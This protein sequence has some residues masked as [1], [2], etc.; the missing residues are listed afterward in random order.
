MRDQ[1]AIRSLDTKDSPI[2]YQGRGLADI[3]VKSYFDPENQAVRQT[4]LRISKALPIYAMEDGSAIFVANGQVSSLGTIY[5]I[6]QG[7]I[8][9]IQASGLLA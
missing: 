5:W 8:A 7:N 1:R 4:L 3:T 9:P 2:P 6:C